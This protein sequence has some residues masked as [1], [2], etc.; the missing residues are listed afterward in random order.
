MDER[1]A[2]LADLVQRSAEE[3]NP[4]RVTEADIHGA[5]YDAEEA[6]RRF[7]L[8]RQAEKLAP[9]AATHACYVLADALLS[10]RLDRL[11]SLMAEFQAER[12][13]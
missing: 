4:Y 8:A 12:A 11:Q 3:A 10:R 6:L 1:N 7:Q 2:H 13:R 5:T 9:S